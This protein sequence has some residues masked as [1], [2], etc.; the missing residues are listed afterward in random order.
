MVETTKVLFLKKEGVYGTDAN[1]T[2]ALNARLTRNF[3]S[4]PLVTD[5]IQRNLDRPVRGRTADAPSNARQTFGYE[6]EMAGS[7]TAGTAPAWM[8]DTEICGMAAPT[9]VAVTSATQRFAAIGTALSSGTA[10]HWRGNQRS[11]GVGARGTFGWDFTAGAYPFLKFD[12]TALLPVASQ[13]P[14]DNAPGAITLDQWI[15][16]LEL[17]TENTLFTLDGY[18]CKLRSWTGDV[19]AETKA[20]ALVG[21]NYVQRGNHGITGRLLVEAPTIAAKNYFLTLKSGQEVEVEMIHGTEPG[22]IVEVLGNHLQILDI[23]YQDED[24]VLMLAISYGMNV[25]TT[26]DDL[27]FTAK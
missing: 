6:L 25:G 13:T 15:D 19:N 18:A 1:P 9:L 14:I 4:K 22:N 3:T 17:N 7:G 21:A 5:R 23:D 16:P 26:N 24:D 12:M 8:E 20:R 2:G 11:T 10:Y 27:I